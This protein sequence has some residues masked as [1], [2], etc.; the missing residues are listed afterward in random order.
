MRRGPDVL[1]YDMVF[2]RDALRL[3]YLGEHW[4]SI[5]PRTGLQ[6]RVDLFIYSLR[7]RRERLRGG[8]EV[9]I[10]YCDIVGYK[11]LK[12]RPRP[13]EATLAPGLLE[14]L[15]RDGRRIRVE[16]SPKVY[17][18]VK[19]AVKKYLDVRLGDCRGAVKRAR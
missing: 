1:H 10:S 17:D 4:E 14:V 2:D 3:I 7:K 16:F 6:R 15:L 18:M 11:L 13:R 9:V 8:E 19:S 12:P 5:R